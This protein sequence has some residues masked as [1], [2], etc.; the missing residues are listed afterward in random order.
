MSKK[1]NKG[2]TKEIKDQVY[3]VRD[4]VLAKIRGYPPWP[5]MVGPSS[6]PFYAFA[7]LTHICLPLFWPKMLIYGFWSSNDA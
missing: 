1:G 5:G 3:D 4:I 2:Q 6:H 7:T